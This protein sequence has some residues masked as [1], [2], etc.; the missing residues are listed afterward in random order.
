MAQ[1][2]INPLSIVHINNWLGL[3]GAFIAA[4]NLHQGLYRAGIQSSFAYADKFPSAL[5]PDKDSTIEIEQKH[6]SFTNLTTAI[7]KKAGL[8]FVSNFSASAIKE[9]KYYKNA[10]LLKFHIIHD[11]YF[12]YLLLPHLTENKPAVW[13]LH[14]MWGFTGHCAYSY[15][16]SKWQ[17][18]CGQCPYPEALPPIQRDATH[19]EWKLKNWA[20][21][22]S[23]LNIVTPSRWLTE[24]TK[25]S[26]LNRFPIHYIPFGIDTEIYQPHNAHNCRSLLNIPNDYKVLLIGAQTLTNPRKGTD[27][28]VKAL[29]GL[30]ENIKVKTILLTFGDSPPTISE[31]VGIKT[32][33]LGYIN[34]DSLKAIVYS[35]AD[36]FLFPTRADIFGLVALEASACGTPTVS[37]NVGGVPDIV[38]SGETGYLAQPEDTDDFCYGIMQLLEDDS[39]LA[40]MG[41]NCRTVAAKEYSLELQAQRYIQ[42]YQSILNL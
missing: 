7:A 41:K 4:Y 25:Q 11:D 20:Y 28:V 35:A 29:S 32:L 37:F 15:D 40:R 27:L 8:N 3:G 24:Q 26:M 1:H 6:H 17:M 39:L 5:Q 21:E 2:Q 31:I 14:D 12:S 23:N 42:L 13:T 10:S 36:L 22:R 9:Q 33:H 34:S 30:P 16:C 19:L 38:R 18:G